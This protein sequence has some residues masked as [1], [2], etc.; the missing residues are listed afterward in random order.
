MT[1][2]H[3]AAI[4]PTAEQE[5]PADPR[6][7][8]ERVAYVWLAREVDA[9]RPVDPATLAAEV[10]V[11]PG[12]ARDLVRVLR[13]ERD[14]DPALGELRSRVVRDRITDAYLVRELQGGQPLDPAELAAEVGTTTTTVA[15]QWLHTLRTSHQADPRLGSLRA[16]P[17][18]HGQPTDEQ[19]AALQAAYAQGGRPEL[20]DRRPAEQA[21]EWIEQLYQAREVARGQPLDPAAMA[22]EV[23]VSEHYVRGT[24]TALR[25]GSLTSAQRI[26]QLWRLWEAEGGQRLAF[27]DVARLL[28]VRE[29]RVRQVLGP[30]R[31]A[32]RT[33]S[34]SAD[35]GER[36]VVVED[37][38]RQGWLDQAACRDHDPERF[39]PESGEQTKAAEAKAICASC[40]VRDQCLDLAVKAAGG[41]DGDHGV[42]GGTLPAERSR[43]RGNT[44]PEP[45]AY[46]QDRE[47]A[48]Q[49]HQ[50][51][52]RVG[53]RQAA[54]QLGVHRDALKGAFTQWGLPKLERRVGWQPSRFLTDRAEAERAYA[55]AEQLGSVN[56]AASQLGT[57]WPSLRKAFTR[58]G[59]G[60]PTRN[61]EAVRQRAVAAARQRSG[62]PVTP[63][64]DPVFVALNPQ[65]VPARPRPP[66]ELHQWVRRDEEYAILGANVVVE[67]NSESRA[68]QPTT[69]AWAIIRRADRAHR[70]PS[71]RQGRSERRQADRATRS[72]RASRSHQPEARGMVA[73]AR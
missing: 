48:E 49:A 5:R 43:L 1:L 12:F 17:V 45:S 31:T 18:S 11:A 46:R 3:D 22:Q 15:R 42:F 59:P 4:T 25:G 33:S 40:Q 44:F 53:L 14:R 2:D 10:S 52:S 27:A 21:L 60:M 51:A 38:G 16:E 29:G 54:R 70:H 13:A 41:I 47:L 65:A 28:G 56:A 61:P 39:F 64:L 36:P 20:E 19:L 7:A 50:L 23:G 24:L 73:D 32:H 37:D 34:D 67:L 66:A 63:P 71:D 9:G 8:W 26:E 58:H 57:T 68:R 6:P 35:R 72:D 30:L 62:Q 55:L 69:R